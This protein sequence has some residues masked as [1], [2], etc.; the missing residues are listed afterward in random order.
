MST[1]EQRPAPPSRW[2]VFFWLAVVYA[3]AGVVIVV[4]S[5][6][7]V[8]LFGSRVRREL[9]EQQATATARAQQSGG[10]QPSFGAPA[11][12]APAPIL[13]PTS[14]VRP[15]DQVIPIQ[16]PQAA[17]IAPPLPTPSP[18]PEVVLAGDSGVPL[19]C[20]D[21]LLKMKRVSETR[22]TFD[23]ALTVQGAVVTVDY[24]RPDGTGIH[25]VGT[26]DRA[27]CS[28][29]GHYDD[30]VGQ[31]PVGQGGTVTVARSGAGF[32]GQWEQTD[33]GS[34][35]FDLLPGTVPDDGV[36]AVVVLPTVLPTLPPGSSP[37]MFGGDS[38]AT[39]AAIQPPAQLSA[40]SIKASASGSA[41]PSLN[42]CNQQ[43]T[44]EPGNAVAGDP[45]TAWRV[46]GDGA[47]TGAYLMLDWVTD[48]TV[49]DVQLVPGYA[50]KDPCAGVEWFPLNRRVKK[51][52][53]DFS[54]GSTANGDLQDAASYQSVHF[55]PVRA[56][57]V[58]I[59]IL[60]T[61]PAPPQSQG[62]RDYTPIGDVKIIGTP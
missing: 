57:W 51:V 3:V 18:T 25:W 13:I 26:L 32:T 53:L 29:T 54:D 2:R 15:A 8:I 7:P 56:K 10:F 41:P 47:S 1:P 12:D 4:L 38:T 28:A 37:D 35:V 30:L 21:L 59:T 52:R 34:G 45:N 27:A 50:K 46:E 14:N 20:D 11:G 62:G 39:P 31:K 49:S 58:K 44:F 19:S 61:Y 22:G 60:D 40:S 17:P 48:F 23:M 16:I 9:R 36:A 24:T 43:T 33:G 42:K 5:L 55:S 6:V